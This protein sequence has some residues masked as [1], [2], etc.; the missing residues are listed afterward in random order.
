M[1]VVLEAVHSLASKAKP[2][3]YAKQWWTAVLTQLRQIYTYWR[4]HAQAER[5]TGRTRAELEQ[6]A[7]GAAKQYPDAILQQKKQHWNEFLADND[8]IWK[9]A[10]YL[11]LL[12]MC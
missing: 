7:K 6:I 5:R 4:N 3:P 1:S 12:N 2:S 8:N 9:V 11:K 10:K